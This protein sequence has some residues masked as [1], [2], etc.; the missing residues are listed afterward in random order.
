MALLMFSQALGGSLFLSFG[1][2]IFTNSLKSLV[3]K[4]APHVDP[5]AIVDA[6]ATGFRDTIANAQDLAGVLAAYADS[7]GRVHYLTTSAAAVSCLTCCF[8]GL[9]DIRKRKQPSKV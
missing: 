2:T 1:S 4:Y 5:L 3:P 7:L 9:K 8:V 6:G